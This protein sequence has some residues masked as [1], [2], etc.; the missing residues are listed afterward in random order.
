MKTKSILFNSAYIPGEWIIAHGFIPEKVIPHQENINENAGEGICPY[1]EL[2]L[3]EAKAFT[4]TGIIFTTRCDQMRRIAE[5]YPK[6]NIFLMNIPATWK[7]PT[8]KK[9]YQD[10]LQ[11]L[12][13]FLIELGG[14]EPDLALVTENKSVT[15]QYQGK[16]LAFMGGPAICTDTE[17]FALIR[18]H[19]AGIS[20]DASETGEFSQPQISLQ[21]FAEAPLSELTSVY[22]SN[23]P[24]IAKRPNSQFYEQSEKIIKEREIEA[25]IIRTYPWCDLWHAEVARIKEYFKLPVLHF[26]ADV[27]TSTTKDTRLQTRLKAFFETLS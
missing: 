15:E 1:A 7:S 6:K 12:S 3:H 20:F 26:T 22:F 10:E 2:M 5:L 18:D 16:K 23:M 11:R 9:I 14:H 8:A 13:H 21:A 25:I 4:G 27:C 17:L 19:G 24:D